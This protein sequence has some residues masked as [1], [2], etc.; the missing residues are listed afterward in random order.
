MDLALFGT[1]KITPEFSV[2]LSQQ[3]SSRLHWIH[4]NIKSSQQ[5]QTGKLP[6]GRNLMGRSSDQL[7]AHRNSLIPSVSPDKVSTSWL[8][9]KTDCSRYGIMMR[10]SA[11]MKE[12]DTQAPSLKSKLLPTR[13]LSFQSATRELY[14]S[15]VHPLM[16]W[17]MLLNLNFLLWLKTKLIKPK[18]SKEALR[19]V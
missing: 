3:R 9:G 10:V 11:I 4:N 16:W 19:I 17:K 12:K 2:Y 14:S 7:K 5:A 1:W 18:A 13:K 15:G 8:E 6:T